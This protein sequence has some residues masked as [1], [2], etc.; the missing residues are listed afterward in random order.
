MGRGPETKRSCT[1]EGGLKQLGWKTRFKTA[2]ANA[3]DTGVLHLAHSL[4]QA[5][6]MFDTTIAHQ[7]GNDADLD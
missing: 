3:D 6:R 2:D 7:I 1:F 5:A 4:E